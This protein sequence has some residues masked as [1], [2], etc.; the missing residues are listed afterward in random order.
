[1]GQ[2][3]SWGKGEMILR[4]LDAS[5]IL[6]DLIWALLCI[7]QSVGILQV[8]SCVFFLCQLHIFVA[9]VSHVRRVRAFMRGN[10]GGECC[11]YACRSVFG[12]MG[13]AKEV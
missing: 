5:S 13:Q 4:G 11:P 9:F 12:L 1:M 7:S 6:M 10:T 8:L 3:G 2:L